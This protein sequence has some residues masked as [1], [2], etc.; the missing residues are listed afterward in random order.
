M[1]CYC[2]AI[3]CHHR[4]RGPRSPD[5]LDRCCRHRYFGFSK[6]LYHFDHFLGGFGTALG[7]LVDCSAPAV[8]S[9]EAQ[10]DGSVVVEA[11]VAGGVSGQPATFLF[12]MVQRDYSLKKGCW[13]TKSCLRRKEQ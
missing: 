10:P 13:M 2:S 3:P 7:D 6:D 5:V 12:T 8:G 9:C 4:T 11:Q 1:V